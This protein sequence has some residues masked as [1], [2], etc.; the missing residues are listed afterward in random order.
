[1]NRHTSTIEPVTSAS[2]A[3]PAASTPRL[4]AISP[5]PTET[6]PNSRPKPIDSQLNR[7]AR[8][9]NAARFIYF[10]LPGAAGSGDRVAQH[11]DPL[12]LKLNDVTDL[13]P[14]LVTM[15]EDAAAGNCP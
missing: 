15:L 4:C 2:T 13:Q 11:A 7:T 9:S 5:E 12:D 3:N 1:M 6:P 8:W 10:K 14:A